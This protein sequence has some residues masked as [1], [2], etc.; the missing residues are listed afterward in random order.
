MRRVAAVLAG[1]CLG[2][3]TTFDFPAPDGGTD[4]DAGAPDATTTTDAGAEASPDA[5]PTS[6][7]S[8]EAA[9]RLCAWTFECPGLA[10]AIE[11]SLVIPVAT[12]ATPLNFSGCMDWLA[13]PVDP[14]RIGLS[15]QRTILQAIAAA[16][17]CATAYAATPAQPVDTDAKCLLDT[18]S[19]SALQTC[20]LAGSFLL[21]CDEPLF[22]Q[23]GGCVVPDVDEAALCVTVGACTPGGS[24]NGTT[25]YV[26]C[27][28]DGASFTAY[29][30]TLSGR[31]C[32]S[33]PMPDCAAPG[34]LAAPCPAHGTDDRCD[35]STVVHCAG[36]VLAETEFDCSHT[37]RTCLQ[38]S[39]AA[40]CMGTNDA[41]SQ[42][43]S[44]INVCSGSAISLCV[45]GQKTSLDCSSIGRMCMPATPTQTPHCG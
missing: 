34:S 43:D 9:A 19:G 41:C 21:Q 7:L 16:S 10:Q 24:C 45:G 12:P 37:Q 5:G 27:Y 1:L 32:A 26:D 4:S 30:C 35:M 17:S 33:G 36:G 14:A 31:I 42:I 40:R 25:T 39:G 15:E 20:T 2:A 22:D 6:F 11:A 18:C 44:D 28:K 3:C 8:L 23:P 13:G 29:D 38:T